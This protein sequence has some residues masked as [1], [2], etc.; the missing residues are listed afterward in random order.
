MQ[1]VDDF[2]AKHVLEHMLDARGSAVFEEQVGLTDPQSIDVCFTPDPALPAEP[3]PPCCE[4]LDRMSPGQTLFE[5]FKDVPDADQVRACLRKLLT[6]HHGQGLRRGSQPQG[7]PGSAQTP[8]PRRS[9]LLA[10]MWLLLPRRSPSLFAEFGASPMADWPAGY[11]SLAPGLRMRFV[12]IGELPRTRASLPLRILGRKP[13]RLAALEDCGALAEADPDR[14]IMLRLVSSL[15]FLLSRAIPEHKNEWR[16][17][18]TWAMREL[19][20]LCEQ[21]EQR[22]EQRALTQSVLDLCA[23]FAVLVTPERERR[24]QGASLEELRALHRRILQ[25]RTWA[26]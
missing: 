5:P 11:Y 14:P 23:A 22:G 25:E 9:V 8:E 19:D 18:M 4:L 21:R 2:L 1:K 13:Q 10:P 3:R 6:Y 17:E 20:Q 26:D 15:Q 12:A 7:L 24:L 16:D